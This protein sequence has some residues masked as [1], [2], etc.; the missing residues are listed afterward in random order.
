MLL[1]KCSN[2]SCLCTTN[3]APDDTLSFFY[4]ELVNCNKFTIQATEFN[5]D[6]FNRLFCNVNSNQIQFR[7]KKFSSDSIQ[8][9]PFEVRFDSRFHKKCELNWNPF[10]NLN[11]LL[12]LW[13]LGFY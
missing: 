2:V 13:C 7:Q 10:M 4:S 8:R 12:H 5:S 6:S 9:R 1:R 11:Q 3:T